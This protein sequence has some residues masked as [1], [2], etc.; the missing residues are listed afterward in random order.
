MET[1]EQTEAFHIL[2]RLRF[3]V[4]NNIFRTM[5]DVCEALFL[6]CFLWTN[7]CLICVICGFKM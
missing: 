6:P 4:I 3:T 7:I 2:L 1:A 5:A